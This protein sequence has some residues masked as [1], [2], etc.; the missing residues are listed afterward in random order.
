MFCLDI[1]RVLDGYKHTKP[2]CKVLRDPQGG[3]HYWAYAG[4]VKDH[5]S[6]EDDFSNFPARYG[7]ENTERDTAS[8]S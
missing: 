8:L 2:F 3:L 7:G 4:L 5:I 1:C 6:S